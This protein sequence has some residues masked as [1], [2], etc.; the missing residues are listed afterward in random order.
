MAA[1]KFHFQKVSSNITSFGSSFWPLKNEPRLI[2]LHFM[3]PPFCAWNGPK[4]PILTPPNH[5]AKT[6]CTLERKIQAFSSQ[7]SKM[8]AL[9]KLFNQLFAF[10][11][12]WP[13]FVFFHMFP[14]EFRPIFLHIHAQAPL[15]HTQ[16]K[17]NRGKR[18]IFKG[19]NHL[20]S[21]P[22][23]FSQWNAFPRSFSAIFVKDGGAHLTI[24]APQVGIGTSI[25]WVPAICD[26]H[27]YEPSYWDNSS[28]HGILNWAIDLL[29]LKGSGT[30]MWRGTS[31]WVGDLIFGMEVGVSAAY[32]EVQ[33]NLRVIRVMAEKIQ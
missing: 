30:R 14:V 16:R 23:D 21:D 5:P 13:V 11:C 6:R 18:P 19:K 17:K 25:V 29:T 4:S 28:M 3:S 7:P 1:R 20:F 12:P 10:L 27:A 2:R 33:K 31:W 26:E 9:S 22:L 15:P 24:F 8:A 32:M